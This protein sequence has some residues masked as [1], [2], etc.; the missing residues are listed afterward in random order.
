MPINNNLQ[1]NVTDMP[2]GRRSK[3][4]MVS[5]THGP[6]RMQTVQ[7]MSVTDEQGVQIVDEFD[8][9]DPIF[10]VREYNGC[11]VN[12]EWLTSNAKTIEACLMDVDPNT[13]GPITY[14]GDQLAPVDIITN[15][16]G[17]N[18]GGVMTGK[19]FIY[20][21]QSA[22]GMATDTKAAE[23]NTIGLDFLRLI[24]VRGIGGI[25]Y[26][27]FTVAPVAY[28][29]TADSAFSGGVGTYAQTAV[30]MPQTN[31]TT[32]TVLYAKYNGNPITDTS[33]YT[34]TSTT[35]TPT[36]APVA[37]DVWEVYTVAV[38]PSAF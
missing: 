21:Q 2:T 18:L 31:G 25:Q 6:W 14:E 16:T 19:L 15:E 4:W 29:T 30:A 11:K 36:N 5:K 1:S 22:A 28:A 35:F 23:K 12:M 33:K 37:G 9:V 10:S 13:A 32:K 34:S 3:P 38:N 7:T 24:R 27:R 8:N 20:G 26:S 17:K